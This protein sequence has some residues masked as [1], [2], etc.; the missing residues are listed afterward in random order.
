MTIDYFNKIKKIIETK[1]GVEA[2]EIKHDSYFQ[3]DLNMSDLEITELLTELEEELH[4]ELIEDKDN[5]ESIN[6]LLDILTEK[7][8]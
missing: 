4:V 6:D 2:E 8:E 7:L 5:I 1:F 3:D